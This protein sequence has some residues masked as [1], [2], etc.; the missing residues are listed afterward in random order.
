MIP[1]QLFL[2]V[3]NHLHQNY[4]TIVSERLLS[5]ARGQLLQAYR[6]ALG[7]PRSTDPKI[8]NDVI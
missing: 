6:H 1:N 7:T 2:E 4:C 8:A 5:I 3:R